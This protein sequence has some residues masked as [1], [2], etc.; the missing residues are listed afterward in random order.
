MIMNRFTAMET[1][2]K[3]Y[4]SGSF[5][6]AARL[7]HVGQP[8]VSKAV[9][10]LETRLGVR[11]LLRST[12]GLTP[13]QAGHDFYEHARLALEQAD[14][15]ER[16]AQGDKAAISGRVRVCMAVTFARLHVIPRL[17]LFFAR[18][19]DIEVDIVLNDGNIDLIENGI[20]LALRMGELA[21][22]SLTVRK[23]SQCPRWAVGTPGYFERAGTPEHPSALTE[24]DVVI[25]DLSGRDHQWTFERDGQRVNVSVSGRL[26]TNAAEGVRESVLAGMG[27]AIASEWMFAPE[28][29]AGTVIPVLTDWRLPSIDLWA[30]FPSGRQSNARTRAFVDFIETEFAGARSEPR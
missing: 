22:S 2:V 11:L 29:A 14:E 25:H 15:A 27:M 21:D 10:Q 8:A 28:L 26:R 16:V 19:P 17:P 4:E 23:I 1:F 13:T 6:S 5:S 7:L 12:Q 20:D 30:V 18:H 24:H 9:A 3:V